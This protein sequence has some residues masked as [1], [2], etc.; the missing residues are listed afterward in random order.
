[1][2]SQG[3]EVLI[4]LI[5]WGT[6][7]QRNYN[8]QQEKIA[9]ALSSY[10]VDVI[11]GSHPHV[12]QPIKHLVD[13]PTG[14]KTLVV[15]S[16]GNFLSNQRFEFV[17]NRY[18]EDGLIVQVKFK[19][20]LETKEVIMENAGYI[21]TW[22][23]RHV[24]NERW[25]YEILPVHQALRNKEKYNLVT[26]DSINRAKMSLSNTVNWIEEHNDEIIQIKEDR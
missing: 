8:S 14:K 1:M 6:E 13:E 20:N 23:N 16:L 12:I 2:K 17:N 19:K 10:G 5:H 7:Y 18:T 22:V 15:Y 24:V 21:P 9:R 25:V 26:E 4:F 3:A 11:F